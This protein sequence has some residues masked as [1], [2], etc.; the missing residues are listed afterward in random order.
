MSLKPLSL[1]FI[2]GLAFAQVPMVVSGAQARADF[3]DY[4][5]P[6]VAV[7]NLKAYHG[8][9][10][11]VGDPLVFTFTAERGFMPQAVK[12]ATAQVKLTKTF[13]NW[14]ER[15]GSG[16]KGGHLIKAESLSL[17]GRTG[18]RF[19]YQSGLN[20]CVIVTEA[21]LFQ[22][23]ITKLPAQF[24]KYI[25]ARPQDIRSLRMDGSDFQE[26]FLTIQFKATRKVQFPSGPNLKAATAEEAR[27]VAQ[28]TACAV[29]ATR[30]DELSY[31]TLANAATHVAR[32]IVRQ[33]VFPGQHDYCVVI[34]NTDK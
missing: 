14:C 22:T 24:T 23:T 19:T 25:T 28:N 16:F 21:D 20:Y 9:D 17:Q 31:A 7:T 29:P 10:E 32:L 8:S 3:T 27:R 11:G 6:D 4:V 12:G 5:S 2:S 33:E 15:T 13:A 26:T 30:A 1:L 34:W 18:E